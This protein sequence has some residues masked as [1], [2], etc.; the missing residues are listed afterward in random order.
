MTLQNIK[1]GDVVKC[2][3]GGRL[4]YALVTEK[5]ERALNVEPISPNVNYRQVKS[6]QVKGHWRKSK[7]S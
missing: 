7:A 3:I 4:F 2:D 5:I 1:V 6:S